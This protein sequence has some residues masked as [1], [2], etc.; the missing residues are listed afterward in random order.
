MKTVHL[1]TRYYC[2][3][4]VHSYQTDVYIQVVTQ[5]NN[6]LLFIINIIYKGWNIGVCS[7]T[8]YYAIQ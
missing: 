2:A 7:Q 1:N 8:C 5:T 6:L 4:C 3:Q